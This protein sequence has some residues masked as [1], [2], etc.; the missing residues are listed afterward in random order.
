ATIEFVEVKDYRVIA[1]LI[2]LDGGKTLAADTVEV[3]VDQAAHWRLATFTDQDNL[4][5]DPEMEVGSST[6]VQQLQ[7]ILAAPTSTLL[8]VEQESVNSSEL[9]LKT[10]MAGVWDPEQ[11]CPPTA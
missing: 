8:T 10:L 1:T 9:L 7:R 5:N 4:F 2:D 6:T 3:V 11:C